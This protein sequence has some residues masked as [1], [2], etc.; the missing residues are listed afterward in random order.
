MNKFLKILNQKLKKMGQQVIPV[1]KKILIRPKKAETK[2]ASGLYLPEIAQKKEYK[3][4]VVGLGQSV[5][6][7]KL[8]DVVQYTE[9]CLPTSMN[10]NGEEHLLIQEGDVFAI[11]VTTMDV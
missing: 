3:G 6:E 11:I 2:T 10:H 8:G 7:I 9:H 4:E 1:G 5:E